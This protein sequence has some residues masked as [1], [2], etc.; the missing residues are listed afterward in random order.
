MDVYGCSQPNTRLDAVL[1]V[2][3]LALMCLCVVVG[4]PFLFLV[5]AGVIA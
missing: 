1:L 4:I 5:A 2:I 3:A